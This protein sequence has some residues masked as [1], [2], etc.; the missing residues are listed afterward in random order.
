M[1][2]MLK[3]KNIEDINS[4]IYPYQTGVFYMDII[5]ECEKMGDYILNVIESVKHNKS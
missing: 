2:N 3:R 5:S 4:N 1:R